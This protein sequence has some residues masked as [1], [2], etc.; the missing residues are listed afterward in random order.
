[1]LKR[2]L[3]TLIFNHIDK[4]NVFDYSFLVDNIQNWPHNEQEF[5]GISK[6]SCISVDENSL[7]IQCSDTLQ[8]PMELRIECVNDELTCVLT[9]SIEFIT[10]GITD[11]ELV[12]YLF[13]GNAI[14]YFGSIFKDTFDEVEINN[15]NEIVIPQEPI[16]KLSFQALLN[17]RNYLPIRSLVE[18][19]NYN[20]HPFS[21]NT[22]FSYY[23]QKLGAD[24]FNRCVALVLERNNNREGSMGEAMNM[25]QTVAMLE[26]GHNTELENL[27]IT[28]IRDMY[29]VPDNIDL[30]AVLRMPTVEESCDDCAMGN[31]IPDISEDRKR[32][33]QPEIEKRRILNSIV[34]G[35]AIHQWTSA[36]FLVRDELNEI[37]PNLIENY[38][39]LS[40]LVNYW[41]WKI[42]QS[43][44]MNMGAM[45]MLQGINKVQL[46]NNPQIEVAGMNFP[47]MIHELS[48]G[49]IDYLISIGIPRDIT[50][51]ELKYLYSVADR[52]Q[53]EQWHYCFGPVI[54]R[55]LL[56]SAD[57][58]S[59]ELPPIISKMAQMTYSEL[60][61]F[62][63]DIVFNTQT[64][65]KTRMD[66]LKKEI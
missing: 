64:D 34:H 61:S 16:E 4:N 63:I 35:C 38:N 46:G 11:L 54:W 30:R 32:E 66:K 18:K 65:G 47:V 62:C 13:D 60:S 26:R 36:Y 23:P 56:Q 8:V 57:V 50:E 1:M 33:L 39:K 6:V 5:Q 44:M 51:D 45:P 49:V 20:T 43:E 17:N 42:D 10:N 25:M 52:Y 53:D 12:N 27:A 21:E 9:R 22:F 41:N 2:K 40:S 15:P 14:K 19:I 55:A 59:R 37:N 24:E 31:D 58:T 7:I 3:T 28:L 29:N 48:K